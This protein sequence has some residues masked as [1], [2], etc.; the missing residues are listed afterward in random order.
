MSTQ[1]AESC[2]CGCGETLASFDSRKRPRR[3]LTGHNLRKPKNPTNW[4]V[5]ICKWCKVQC[6]R[7]KCNRRIFCSRHCKAKWMGHKLANDIDYKE[8]QRQLILSMGNRPPRHAGSSHWN[9]KGGI[10]PANKLLRMSGEYRLWRIAVFRRDNYTC[11]ECRVRGGQLQAHHIKRWS[12][13]P[14]LRF[15]V[16]N[17]VTLCEKCHS[18]YPRRIIS[19]CANSPAPV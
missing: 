14:D 6:E 19:P 5:I 7:R 4:E 17:G 10:T 2:A 12:D 11:Q 16:P 18:K 9:W 1:T 15:D 3:Y 8:R 13:Y